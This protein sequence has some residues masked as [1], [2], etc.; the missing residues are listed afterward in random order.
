MLCHIIALYDEN[1]HHKCIATSTA[2][3]TKF[4][5]NLFITKFLTHHLPCGLPHHHIYDECFHLKDFATSAAMP[6][7]IS[8]ME[9]H[10]CINCDIFR[11]TYDEL[12][13][14]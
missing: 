1:M 3:S 9:M 11:P 7:V 8:H 14:H 6:H 5:M 4:M 2:T 10:N 12:K 13:C